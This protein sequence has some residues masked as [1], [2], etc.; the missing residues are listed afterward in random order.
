MLILA[1][2]SVAARFCQHL[3][4]ILAQDVHIHFTHIITFLQEQ[5][6]ELLAVYNMLCIYYPGG[7]HSGDTEAP[8][9]DDISDDDES[10]WRPVEDGG[11]R[12]SGTVVWTETIKQIPLYGFDHMVAVSEVSINALFAS[13]HKAAGCLAKW[14]HKKRFEGQFSNIR[15]KLLSGNKALVT[16]AINEGYITLTK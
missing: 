9:F 6:M 4:S 5:Y 2:Q 10:E 16:F 14:G 13:L 8:D 11:S 15:V 7:Y 12:S 1:Q 3:S